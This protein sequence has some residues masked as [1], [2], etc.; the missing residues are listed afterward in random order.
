MQILSG[1]VC[2]SQVETTSFHC[3]YRQDYSQILNSFICT[4]WLQ[5]ELCSC[6]PCSS[7]YL[8]NPVTQLSHLSTSIF[9]SSLIYHI[10]TWHCLLYQINNLLNLL[11]QLPSNQCSVFPVGMSAVSSNLLPFWRSLPALGSNTTL[12]PRKVSLLHVSSLMGKTKYNTF[13]PLW[14]WSI[15]NYLQSHAAKALTVVMSQGVSLRYFNLATGKSEHIGNWYFGMMKTKQFVLMINFLWLVSILFN[16]LQFLCVFLI[17]PLVLTQ[18][19]THYHCAKFQGS[20]LCTCSITS[21]LFRRLQIMVVSEMFSNFFPISI[22]HDTVYSHELR[23]SPNI[24]AWA[25]EQYLNFLKTI[26]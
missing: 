21:L 16:S 8:S 3:W 12:L 22:F 7:R 10:I 19:V 13:F 2:F 14:R 17:H 15:F 23:G 24:S 4:T 6:H 25:S 9:L 18:S 26:I 1:H 11:P 5:P 20:S